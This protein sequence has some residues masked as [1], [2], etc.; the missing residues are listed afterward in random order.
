MSGL[1]LNEAISVLVESIA[2]FP[3]PPTI[4]EQIRDLQS[5]LAQAALTAPLDLDLVIAHANAL[6]GL[7]RRSTA[8]T[9]LEDIKTMRIRGTLSHDS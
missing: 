2:H 8:R 3:K 5:K 9:Q 7:E 1:D 6:K 4:G